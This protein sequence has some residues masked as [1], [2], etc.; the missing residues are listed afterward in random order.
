[1]SDNIQLQYI[2]EE[3]YSDNSLS[4][5]DDDSIEILAVYQSDTR[6]IA[7]IYEDNVSITLVN[8]YKNKHKTGERQMVYA[9]IK[10]RLANPVTTEMV[11]G[12]TRNFE[13]N[14][15]DDCDKPKDLSGYSATTRINFGQDNIE[16]IET[17]VDDNVVKFKIDPSLTIGKRDALW[18]TRLS[19]PDGDVISL[20]TGYLKI[21][22]SP[23][24]VISL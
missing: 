3:G 1:M 6:L 19:S 17:S 24:P 16:N 23:D 12:T 20:A 22:K 2:S 5:Q 8:N 21:I 9:Y 11:E 15:S 10:E 14:V 4:C 7:K 13:I 18:E